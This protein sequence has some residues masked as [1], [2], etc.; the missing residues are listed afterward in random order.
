MQGSAK[1]LIIFMDE[2]DM[3]GEIP[4]YESVVKW[5]HQQ[6]IAG[7]TVLRGIM[8]YGK[9]HLVHQKRLFGISD[10]R[11]LTLLVVEEEA[12]LREIIP[13]IRSM[14]KDCPIMLLDAQWIA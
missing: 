10:D 4:L 11:P 1:L 5:L 13:E 6:R 12:R 14:V 2:S 9:T 3:R 7:A 8:G